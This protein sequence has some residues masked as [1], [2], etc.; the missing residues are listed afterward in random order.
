[1]F[2]DEKPSSTWL[3]RH[4]MKFPGFVEEKQKEKKAL[5]R[6]QKKRDKF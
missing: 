2:W 1:M 5:S 4:G 6:G 3:K